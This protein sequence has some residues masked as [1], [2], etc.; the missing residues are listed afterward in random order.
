MGD[1]M[2]GW[3]HRLNGHDFGF[4]SWW[5]TGRPGMLQSKGSQRFRHNWATELNWYH[6]TF[7]HVS[8]DTRLDVFCILHIV[9][10]A[11]MNAK[12]YLSVQ[13]CLF[14]FFTYIQMSW[15]TGLYSG[16]I[17]SLL[18]KYHAVFHNE[19]INLHSYQQ[20]TMFL[21]I[22]VICG[23]FNSHFDIYEVMSHCGF[24]FHFSDDQKCWASC[25]YLLIICR[26]FPYNIYIHLLSILKWIFFFFWFTWKWLV[27]VLY[28]PW[29]LIPYKSHI[30]QV[31]PHI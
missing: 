28:M 12:V 11:T 27:W 25:M 3:H 17:F 23:I 26:S 5:Q 2:V 4:R 29:I 13:N 24:N 10:N 1:E 15:I 9:I 7:I 18:R 6:V 30:L 8:V 22:F 19:C 31:F 14:I 20:C 16:V 21:S